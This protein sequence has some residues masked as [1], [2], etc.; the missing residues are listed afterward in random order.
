MKFSQNSSG[1]L[2]IH[3]KKYIEKL[4]N[5]YKCLFDA[6]SKNICSPHME[7]DYPELNFSNHLNAEG[8]D[9]YQSIIISLKCMVCIGCFNIFTAVMTLSNHNIML[10]VNYVD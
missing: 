6:F 2:Y 8:I 5:N 4:L 10:H 1:A 3:Y 7:N 9:F